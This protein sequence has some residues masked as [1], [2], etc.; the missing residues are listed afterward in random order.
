MKRTNPI[1]EELNR[2][3]PDVK[4]R[5][6]AQIEEFPA[7]VRAMK[8]RR[9]LWLAFAGAACA[10][11]ILLVVLLIPHPSAATGYTMFLD[12]NPSIRLEADANDIVISQ[13][14]M[15][16]DGII[17][18]YKESVVGKHVDEATTYL[19]EKMKTAGLLDQNGIVRVSVIDEKTGTHLDEK[20]ND[21]RT[22]I[23]TYFQS[24]SIRTLFLSDE[25]LDALEEYY[26]THRIDEYEKNFL[27]K[28]KQQLKSAI[29][30]KI[31]RIGEIL[32]LLAKNGCD[33]TSK[34]K[35]YTL[36]SSV[37][38]PL[39]QYCV[40][41]RQ[42]WLKVS[43]TEIGEWMED[44]S[45]KREDLLERKQDIHEEEDF[46]DLFEDLIDIV[47]DELFGED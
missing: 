8:K 45:E 33:E 4:A 43:V 39:L 3:A 28:Y 11:C 26:E 38:L 44:L 32:D 31:A 7:P 29:D 9:P 5:I 12:V 34:E 13:S 40:K 14:G 25:D 47:K 30:E 21:L 42:N 17:L 27:L 18:L 37:Q 10:L 16:E 6:R 24:D 22:T 1:R 35:I 36:P 19:I 23:E 15:N 46:S 20:Q 41:Y 2:R